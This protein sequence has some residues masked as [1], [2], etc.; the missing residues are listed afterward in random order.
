M[1]RGRAWRRTGG[2][3]S[4]RSAARRPGHLGEVR[5]GAAGLDDLPAALG[6]GLFDT[7]DELKQALGAYAAHRAA[8]RL[9][10]G[11]PR[12]TWN[13]NICVL[14]VFYQWA[15]AEGQAGAVPFTYAQAMSRYG[16]QVLVRRTWRG[17]GPR[18]RM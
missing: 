12:S 10:P 13:Q 16:D 1:C 17:G 9:R 14:S 4:C 6:I 8:A 18:S 3:G 11:G 15:V 7:R 5:A 2:C